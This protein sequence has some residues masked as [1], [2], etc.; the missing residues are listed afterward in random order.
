MLVEI[1]WSHGQGMDEMACDEIYN[2]KKGGFE[3]GSIWGLL[4]IL[5]LEKSWEKIRDG[6]R[7]PGLFGMCGIGDWR[8]LRREIWLIWLNFA[9]WSNKMSF[10]YKEVEISGI[11]VGMIVS[12]V[13]L[14]WK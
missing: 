3:E 11:F 1:N 13:E 14:D 7:K 8:V 6:R 5:S 4:R 12:E 9:W 10:W 2:E